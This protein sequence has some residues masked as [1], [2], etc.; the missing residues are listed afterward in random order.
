MDYDPSRITNT[1]LCLVQ[2]SFLSGLMICCLCFSHAGCAVLAALF[3]KRGEGK[4]QAAAGV[5]SV[6]FITVLA[7]GIF[8]EERNI[9]DCC[10]DLII[11]FVDAVA[12]AGSSAAA[13][14][15]MQTRDRRA[16]LGFEF[17]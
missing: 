9:A 5:A 7:E 15:V 4:H 17:F 3:T 2:I 12:D 10:F 6:I 8:H 1:L 16:D 13:V 11:D 14:Y